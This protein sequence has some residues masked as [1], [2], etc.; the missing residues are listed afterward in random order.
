VILLSGEV[1]MPAFSF[2]FYRVRDG[3]EIALV[4]ARA[5]AGSP[6]RARPAARLFPSLAKLRERYAELCQLFGYRA[7]GESAQ[8]AVEELADPDVAAASARIRDQC[9]NRIEGSLASHRRLVARFARRAEQ[10]EAEGGRGPA[11]HG[12]APTSPNTDELPCAW[13]PKKRPSDG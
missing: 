3:D 7:D 8:R 9:F 2:A 5:R 4:R 10:K 1:A 11:A 13:A 12:P 6:P